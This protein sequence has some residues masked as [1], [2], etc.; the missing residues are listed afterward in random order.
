M[1]TGRMQPLQH[2][3]TVKL[4]QAR[5][6]QNANRAERTNL[7]EKVLASSIGRDTITAALQQHAKGM[8]RGIVVLDD[9]H[10]FHL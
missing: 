10:R 2:R 9:G 7:S 3:Q 5:F 8:A 1:T 4:R 6:Q